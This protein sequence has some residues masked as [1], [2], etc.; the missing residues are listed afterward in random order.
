MARFECSFQE[1]QGTIE[2]ANKKEDMQD[3][4]KNTEEL[5]PIRAFQ[6]FI[7]TKWEISAKQLSRKA[8]TALRAIT[9]LG[10][11][12]VSEAVLMGTFSQLK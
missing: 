5:I 3:I 10:S 8:S 9:V 6:R 11:G 4:M 7:W 2:I 12:G 1:Y